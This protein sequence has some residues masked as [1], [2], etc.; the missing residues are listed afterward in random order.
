MKILVL[1]KEVPDMEKVRFDSQRGVVDRSSAP[2]ELNPFDESAL[3]AAL[4][5]KRKTG[6]HVTV[7]TMGP[8]R[9]ELTL[10]DA[11]AR[12]AD[13]GILLTDRAFG[14][15]DTFATSRTLAAAIATLDYDLILC[16]E[17]SVDGDTAQVRRC[18]G[19]D[20]LHLHEL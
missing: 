5:L 20:P 1:L 19:A 9:A 14:G 11:C 4:D 6:A 13:A 10:Q 18:G 3:Q 15:A 7:L 12:G 17:K 8:P 2:A 16:G